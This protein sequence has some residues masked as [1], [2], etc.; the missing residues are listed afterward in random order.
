MSLF[1]NLSFVT[2]QSLPLLL[3]V[4]LDGFRYDY[5]KLH[6]PLLNFQRLEQRGVRTHS[7]ISTFNTATIPNHYTY[8]N[9]KSE[10]RERERERKQI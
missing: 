7:M 10:E 9:T 4:S 6:G 5:S 1:Y 3:I 2:S 8:V